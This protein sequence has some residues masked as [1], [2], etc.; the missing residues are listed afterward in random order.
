MKK[1]ILLLCILALPIMAQ[2]GGSTGGLSRA[3]GDLEYLMLD[4][5]NQPMTGY[6]APVQLTTAQIGALSP[7][8]DGGSAW[9]TD[10]DELKVFNGLTWEVVATGSLAYLPLAG[11]QLTGN[12]TF[13]GAQ[14]VD[15]R[16]L[17]VDGAKLD[18]VE[19]LADVTDTANV[20]G[21]GALMR[22]GGAMSGAITTS[23]TFDGRDLSVDGTKL[24]LLSYTA[25]GTGGGLD[26][27]T[28]DGQE[29]VYY[30]VAADVVPYSGATGAVDLGAQT[31]DTTGTVTGGNFIGNDSGADVDSRIEGDTEV[32]LF[33]V[34]AGNDRIGIG[35]ATPAVELDVVGALTATGTVTGGS[36]I[37]AGNITTSAGNLNIQGGGVT[38][39]TSWNNGW[40]L[41]NNIPIY[42]SS[43]TEA[44]ASPDVGFARDSAG[45]VR[46]TDGGAGRGALLATTGGFTGTVT[47]SM[48]QVSA[49]AG[50][51]R[52]SVSNDYYLQLNAGATKTLLNAAST[53]P[54]QLA[55]GG[56]VVFDVTNDA[57]D[58]TATVSAAAGQTGNVF[59]VI[60]SDSAVD[61]SVS[62]NGTVTIG[63]GLTINDDFY[64]THPW[65]NSYN[66]GHAIALQG[67]TSAGIRFEGTSDAF[68]THLTF[69][70]P[71]ADQTQTFINGSGSIGLIDYGAYPPATCT[72][73]QLFIDTDETDDTT[74][75]TTADNSIC[76][77]VA[78]NTWTVL[79]NN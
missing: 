21:A 76:I 10:T 62:A 46:V 35:T 18:G 7:L 72:P 8:I 4:G 67:G 34:D 78:T 19:A 33:Y 50:T 65:Y 60:G 28:L 39:A 45:V 61:L 23:S 13:S 70:D 31:L 47:G 48:Y 77:C 41:A 26:S 73:P 44:T 57:T 9:D 63:R 14:T 27:D 12:I 6:V 55:S 53:K 5:T 52:S 15:G 36:F 58:S 37:T 79:E 24:D 20:A 51:I 17:S 43:T 30:G 54:V 40:R 74:I 66:A 75:A 2:E 29:G 3:V 71:T 59:E 42:W 56:V 49:T 11:G 25:E 68:E 22:T 64:G 1:L 32:N 38:K 69:A 16:D